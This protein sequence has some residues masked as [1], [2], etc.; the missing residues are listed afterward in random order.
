VRKRARLSAGANPTANRPQW[1]VVVAILAVFVAI[2][3]AAIVSADRPRPHPSPNPY[4]LGIIENITDC[5][6]LQGQLNE[7]QEMA[8]ALDSASVEFALNRQYLNA[9]VARQGELNCR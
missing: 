9:L 3:A 4:I 6:L 5:R 2:A 7:R 8:D 1:F